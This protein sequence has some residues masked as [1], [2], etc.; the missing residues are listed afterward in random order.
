MKTKMIIACIVTVLSLLISNNAAIALAK[1]DDMETNMFHMEN[2]S[3]EYIGTISDVR[4]EFSKPVFPRVAISFGGAIMPGAYRYDTGTYY[5]QAGE[6]YSYNVT[7]TPTG[8]SIKICR[9]NVVT[10]QIYGTSLKTGGSASGTV[11]SPNVP[12][13]EYRFAIY[14]AGTLKITSCTCYINF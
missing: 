11:T 13:G 5:I 1:E 9:V 8:Q 12:S 10:G 14:N 7:W 4:I 6:S 2:E 3:E